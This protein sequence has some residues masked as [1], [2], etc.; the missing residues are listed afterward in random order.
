[1]LPEYFAFLSTII[2]SLGAIQYLWLTATGKVQPN[3]V[4]YFFWGLFPLIAFFAQSNQEVSSVMW[5]TLSMGVLPFAI[6][7]ASFVNPSAYWKIRLTDYVLAT[8]AVS[9]MI[10]WYITENAILAIAFALI[11]D[12]FASLPTIIKSYTHPNSEDWRPYAVNAV[13][14]FVGLL[15]VQDWVFAE[16]SF[17][18]YFFLMTTL[19]SVLIYTRQRV[20]KTKISN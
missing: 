17:V 16:Y 11:A 5:I 10:A 12:M 3:R 15:A 8:V 19:F 2:A 9:S 1:M 7:I 13:G 14:F 6:L 20:L 18:L 4:T